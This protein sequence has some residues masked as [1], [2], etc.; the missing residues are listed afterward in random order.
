MKLTREEKSWIMYDCGNSAY[1]MAV[2]TAFLPIIFGMFTNVESSMDLGYFNSLASI[3]VAILSPILGTIADYKDKKKRFFI[4]F[5]IVGL[6]STLSLAFVGPES[7]MWQLLIL[8][9]I[10][11]CI[12]FAGANI[13]YDAFLVDI[14]SDERMDKVS[15]SGFAYG[16]IASIIP[17]GISLAIVYFLGMDKAI[18]YQVG[19]IITALWWGLFTIPMLRNVHQKHYVESEPRPVYNSF[20]RLI[21][22][23]KEI[24]NYKVVFVFLIA[25]FLY[26][27][28][29][30]TIIK[31]VVPYASSVIGEGSLD[32]FTLL[33]ILLIIQI[34]AF[35]CALLYGSLAKKYSARAMI[36]V[37]IIT[38]IISCVAAYFISEVWHIFILGAMIGSAQGGIQALSRSYY[39]KIIPKE[40]SNEF[41]GFYNI[42]GK[43]A[44]II[45]PALMALVTEVTGNARL[46]IFS[47]I[48]LFVFGLIIFLTLPKEEKVYE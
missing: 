35:P 40:N 16:Y 6:L 25:Y 5:A 39:G 28:G 46:S 13:F 17:F 3:I 1:S 9:Y 26:I 24:K 21:H 22:T 11:S 12:G 20:K 42:F 27:D 33:A 2:T 7:G 19:F 18:G 15:A 45:G 47:I 30:D 48:P 44:A 31:M 23:F 10:L 43:F 8:F 32:V 29:V 41:F 38:Y 34:I 36:I 4:F 37:G 14:T